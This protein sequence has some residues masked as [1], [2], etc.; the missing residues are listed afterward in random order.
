ML[1]FTRRLAISK[2]ERLPMELEKEL[3][4]SITWETLKEL[5]KELMIVR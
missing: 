3:P 1:A 2:I 4:N 5:K